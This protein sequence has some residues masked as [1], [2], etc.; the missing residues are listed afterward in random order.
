MA[1]YTS[2]YTGA[3]IDLSVASGSSA[4]GNISSSLAGTGSFGHLNVKG[5]AIITGSLTLGG[6]ITIGD[7]DSDS[8]DINAD[9]TSNLI[10]NA[11]NTI[12]IG[13]AAKSW[14]RVFA[15]HISGSGNLTITTTGS[16]GA[17]SSTGTISASG[18]LGAQSRIIVYS[19]TNPYFLAKESNTEF[20][21]MGV[22]STGGDMQIGWD[23][24]DDLHLGVLAS[25]ADTVID[26][27]MIIQSDGNVGIGEIGHEKLTVAGN[28]S[29]SGFISA[30]GNLSL[31]GNIELTE[32]Q[33]I[34]FEADKKTYLETHASDSFRVVVNN[35]QML[36]LDEDTGNRAVFGNGTKVYIGNNNNRQ[37]D[38]E[39]EIEGNISASNHLHIG[40][41]VNVTGSI[42]SKGNISGSS[43]STG[44]FGSMILTNL[45]TVQP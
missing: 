41:N 6:N 33:R 25:P 43:T 45:P 11:D 13:S 1:D 32:D 21:K 44:S 27:K 16:F 12:D 7:A 23:D 29:S 40:G 36:I 28:I 35:S 42:E 18:E 31:G 8:L 38:F 5:D 39:L 30:S 14:N 20:L 34:F 15:H 4:F 24:S 3:Q 19:D 22:E 2:K 26:T 9:L 10:P 37:P 17:V